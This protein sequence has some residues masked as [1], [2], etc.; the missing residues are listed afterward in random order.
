MAPSATAAPQGT[1]GTS[2][3]TITATAATVSA[4]VISASPATGRQF[5]LRS[6]GDASNAASSSTGATKSA[7]A[8]SGS[9]LTDGVP[10]MSAS[11]APASAMR[12]G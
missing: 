12:A 8:S 3:R 9:R 7:S 10:G 2:H 11:A 6:R 5:S 4:T 1:S